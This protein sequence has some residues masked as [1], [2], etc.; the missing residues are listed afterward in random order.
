[1]DLEFY[2]LSERM[3]YPI[4]GKV[5]IGLYLSFKENLRIV[6]VKQ[7]NRINFVLKNLQGKKDK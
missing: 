3:I 6:V 5:K 7:N 1:M 2:L 4:K